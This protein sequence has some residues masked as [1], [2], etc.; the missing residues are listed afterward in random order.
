MGT[1]RIGVDVGGTF[2]DVALSLDGG[3]V[4]AKV[5]TTAD[6][7]EG[8]IAGIRTACAEAGVDPESVGEFSHAMTVSVN[9]LLE[10][11]GAR[12][13]LVTTEGFRDVLEIGRQD[14]PSLYDLDA[15]KPTP[16]VPRRRRFEVDERATADG[17]ERPVDGDEVR[18]LAAEIRET[19][20]ESVAVSLLHAY[21]HPENERRVAEVLRSALDVPVSAS[22]EVLAEF[23]EYERTSTTVVDAYVR[24]AIDRYVGRLTERAKALGLPRP[25]IMQANGGITDAETVRRNAVTTVLSGPAAGV[26]GASAMAAGER[27]GGGPGRADE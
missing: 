5:P 4:T 23:R 24:P 25:R 6:Q 2:T 18:A 19:D 1:R 16:L 21:A 22:H 27:D 15:E 10:G 20:A 9:A 3:L 12:T 26:V 13:A 7:S 8:V 17:V 14:R 11:D